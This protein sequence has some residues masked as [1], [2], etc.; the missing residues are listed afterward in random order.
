MHFLNNYKEVYEVCEQLVKPLIK[1]EKGIRLLG[2]GLSNLD[3]LEKYRQLKL[4]F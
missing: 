1:E 2:V 4:D 3:N